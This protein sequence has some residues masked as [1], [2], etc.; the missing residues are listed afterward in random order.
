MNRTACV[1]LTFFVF[2]ATGCEA[3]NTTMN[4]ENFDWSSLEFTCTKEKNPPFDDE[5]DHWYRTARN[6]QKKDEERYATEI[7]DLY[8]RA[9]E[10]DHF[11]AMHRLALMYVDGVGVPHDERKAVELVERVIDLGLASGYYQMGVFLQQGIGVK[12]DRQASL[13]YI[14]KAA[15]MG[16]REGQLAVGQDLMSIEEKDIRTRV[17]PIAESM[18]KCALSQ[19]LGEAG[20]ELGMFYRVVDGKIDT[21]LKHFQAAGKL[22]SGKSL[23]AL[24]RIFKEGH[25]SVEKDPVRAACYDRLWREAD[26]DKYKKFPDLDRVCPL[27]PKR[28]PK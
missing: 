6:L 2:F 3:R 27:P 13:T 16:N 7:A 28:M 25:S 17:V 1:A 11:N 10:R 5:A 14:R 21:A 15:D 4:T 26:A 24:Y 9:I 19:G 8:R 12:Q 23:F 18:L 22:G 20:Y